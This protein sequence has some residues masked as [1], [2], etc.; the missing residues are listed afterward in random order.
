MLLQSRERTTG[1]GSWT[2]TAGLVLS[3]LG[4]ALSGFAPDASAHSSEGAITLEVTQSDDMAEVKATLK[5]LGD[6]DVA[7][8]ATVSATASAT[9]GTNVGPVTLTPQ[10]EGVYRGALPL[11]RPGEWNIAVASDRP[12]ATATTT[13]TVV[14][15]TTS[16]RPPSSSIA[17]VEERAVGASADDGDDSALRVIAL[18]VIVVALVSATTVFVVRRTRART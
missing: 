3:F 8:S 10:G 9:D 18:A 15:P 6:G 2:L 14:G 17:A 4:L 1:R 16:T 11:D 12:G 5:Y 7:S 13:F